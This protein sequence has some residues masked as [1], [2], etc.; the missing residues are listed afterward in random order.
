[1]ITDRYYYNRLSNKEK[2]IYNQLYKS[3]I[4]LQPVAKVTGCMAMP[5]IQKIIEAITNDNPH[6][7]Y[8]NQTEIRV[9]M[10]ALCSNIY[11][12]YFFSKSEIV[13]YNKQIEDAVNKIVKRLQLETAGSEYEIE[14][15]VH[16]TL[17]SHLE[18]DHSAIGTNNKRHLEIS[19]SI[20]CVFIEK[21]AV[22]EGIAKA[23]KIL[24]NTANIHCI[25]VTGNSTLEKHGGHA[26]NI[27]R[28]N[29]SAYHLDITWDIANSTKKH[30]NYDYFNLNDIEISKDHSDFKN[31]PPCSS[32]EANYYNIENLIFSDI[33]T[34]KKHI[35]KLIKENNYYITIKWLSSTK[36]INE[37]AE[38]LVQFSLSL[39]A[40]DGYRWQARYTVNPE[41]STL[42]IFLNVAV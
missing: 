21:K 35:K 8:F 17:A 1:M 27:V 24:L 34:A 41:Q 3:I 39:A 9:Q 37:T 20:V 32:S 25:V 5:V 2:S 16:D 4:D 7:Y 42:K 31:V 15:R 10:S 18:Y 12:T 22:C 30:I 26:W 13:S 6:L 36:D 11:L 28:I 14:K 38:T 19:H 33:L 40:S 29:N 23:A